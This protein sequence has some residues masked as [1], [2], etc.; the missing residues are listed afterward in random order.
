MSAVCIPEMPV[1][2]EE[3]VATERSR[4]DKARIKIGPSVGWL[5][6]L[7]KIFSLAEQ[8]S[9]LREAGATAVEFNMYL[10]EPQR[11][12]NLADT[13]VDL[14]PYY[15]SLHLDGRYPI[16]EQLR[17]ITDINNKH[18]IAAAVIHPVEVPV[19][20]WADLASSSPVPIAIENMDRDK[21]EGID[22]KEL[23]RLLEF[24]GFRLAL[25]VQH[26]FEQDPAMVYA[27]D[28]LDETLS[29][30]KGKIAHLHLSGEN[31]QNGGED[32]N[33]R[34]LHKSTNAEPIL[35]F[36]SKVLDEV[37]VSIILEGR[38]TTEEELRTEIGF[39][40][41]ELGL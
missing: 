17:L 9:I 3:P 6:Y 30:R 27:Q 16:G 10:E 37:N 14:S 40:T 5:C 39:I 31:Y 2:Q 34:L 20:Y 22:R 19:E 7:R 21:K 11:I 23:I 13:D 18:G 1:A 38:F 4:E 12:E 32:K 24:F 28:L 36:A 41:N 8:M 35:E 33:H 29:L 26:A 25:D 15:R